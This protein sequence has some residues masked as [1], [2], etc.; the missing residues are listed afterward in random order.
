MDLGPLR[1][2]ID[3]LTACGP[4]ALSD[5]ESIAELQVE[6]AR[7]DALVTAAVAAFEASGA[8]APSGAA[9]TAAAWITH[10]CRIPKKD[11]ARQ[12]RR[13][14]HCRHLPLFEAAWSKGEITADHLDLVASVRRPATEEA[15][16]RD[17]AMLV[18][19]ATTL[20]YAEF[21]K[22]LAY[23]EQ[24]ADPDGAEHD[25][26]ERRA[27]RDVY[28]VETFDGTFLGRMTFDAISG[29][30]VASELATP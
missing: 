26:M 11:A 17:E 30:I 13:G 14:R 12:V 6:R 16:A 8:W 21:A 19:Q 29:A 22:V 28:L 5:P 7:L 24:H 25:A 23:W 27:R 9:R 4:S 20:T 18:E 3:E 2:A 10:E 15:L 1:A